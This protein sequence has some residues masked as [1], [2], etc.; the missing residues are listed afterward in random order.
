MSERPL[1]WVDQ[2]PAIDQRGEFFNLTVMSGSAAS[3]FVMTRHTLLALAERARHKVDEAGSAD[4]IS[5]SPERKQ[6]LGD[7]S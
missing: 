3:S 6:R 5:F 4:V 2:V 1:Y 7:E